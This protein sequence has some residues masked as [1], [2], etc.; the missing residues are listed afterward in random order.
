MTISSLSDAFVDNDKIFFD[1]G[2][3]SYMYMITRNFY[4][5]HIG[6]HF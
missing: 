4:V 3:L 6:G 5:L 2:G 1:K